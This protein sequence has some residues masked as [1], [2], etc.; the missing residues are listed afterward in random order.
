MRSAVSVAVRAEL[1]RVMWFAK[2]MANDLQ[3]NVDVTADDDLSDEVLSG[4]SGGAVVGT[5]LV[6]ADPPDPT[7]F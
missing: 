6:A 4:V 3:D 1:W 5:P 7:L 2:P